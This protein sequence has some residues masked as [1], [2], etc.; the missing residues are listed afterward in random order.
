MR[1]RSISNCRARGVLGVFRSPS[2]R[3]SPQGRGSHAPRR[4]NTPG[5][6]DSPT[7]CRPFSLSLGAGVRGNSAHGNPTFPKP[8]AATEARALALLRRSDSRF[9]LTLT[10]SPRE[11]KQ[12]STVWEEYSLNSEHFP[13]L[14]IVLPLPKGEGW[15]EGE[16]RFLLIRFGL[17][18]NATH[19]PSHR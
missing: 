15:G 14:P 12:L 10:L 3:P 4:S 2:P 1:F 6:P 13:A 7:R 5:A 8:P 17:A 9:P 18:D 19:L 11:R 16:G